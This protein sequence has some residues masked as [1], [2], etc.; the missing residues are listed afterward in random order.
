MA[1]QHEKGLVSVCYTHP[2]H[3][4]TTAHGDDEQHIQNTN[5]NPLFTTPIRLLSGA[6]VTTSTSPH[7]YLSCQRITT[8]TCVSAAVAASSIF[9]QLLSQVHYTSIPR[10]FCILIARVGWREH[11][12]SLHFYPSPLPHQQKPIV[13]DMASR[14]HVHMYKLVWIQ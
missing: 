5:T 14:F 10:L 13:L 1:E 12:I 2:H 8:S 6:T 7:Q 3:R 9:W 11:M 4:H